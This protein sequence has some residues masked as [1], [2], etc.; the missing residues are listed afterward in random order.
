MKRRIVI[1]EPSWHA[2][3]RGA[4]FH[5][6]MMYLLLSSMLLSTAGLCIHSILKADNSDARLA[7]SL[8]SLLRLENG[9]RQDAA[10]A[11]NIK[12]QADSVT[13]ANTVSGR[14]VVWSAKDNV[15]R[16]EATSGGDA[17]GMDRFVF[18]KGTTFQIA[19]KGPKLMLTMREPSAMPT[20]TDG[21]ET[22]SPSKSVQIIVVVPVT[23][24]EDS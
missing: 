18:P 4:V 7:A 10:V 9:L 20:T 6:Y 23:E 17:V 19:G 13:L 5:Y 21:T 2:K 14:Q 3:R 22:V 16:R 24:R 12:N 11:T 15:V 1:S 8:K